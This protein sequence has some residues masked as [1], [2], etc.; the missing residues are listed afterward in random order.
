MFSLEKHLKKKESVLIEMASFF[1]YQK[2]LLIKGTCIT[3]YRSFAIFVACVEDNATM[4][5]IPYFEN[6]VS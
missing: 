4:S 2:H 6:R 5:S 1:F 3:I